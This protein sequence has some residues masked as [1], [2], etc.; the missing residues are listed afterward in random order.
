MA[1]PPPIAT[2]ASHPLAESLAAAS[3]TRV[4]VGSP[5][6]F[7][8]RSAPASGASAAA[9]SATSPSSPASITTSGRVAP[10]SARTP[11]RSAAT[12]SPKRIF[13]GR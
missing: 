1:E 9:T 11:A 8:N 2:T 6:A 13:T 10:S 3:S 7:S 5:G 4:T 12:P